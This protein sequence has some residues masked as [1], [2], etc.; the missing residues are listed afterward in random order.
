MNRDNK[1]AALDPALDHRREASRLRRI[2]V[3]SAAVGFRRGLH[4]E[5]FGLY[6]REMAD[7]TRVLVGADAFDFNPFSRRIR[8]EG[9]IAAEIASAM[10]LPVVRDEYQKCLRA[11][12]DARS[13]AL[14][15]GVAALQKRAELFGRGC[16]EL[17]EKC[18]RLRNALD[19]ST[20]DILDAM[21]SLRDV[22]DRLERE[23]PDE[24][25]PLPKYREM[26]F[27]Y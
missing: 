24:T 8:I 5:G 6:D 16:D 11:L 14:T 12:G 15:Q 20:E 22:A 27:I 17:D 19:N 3:G 21:T 1:P 4:L 13:A 18:A 23:A 7:P 9:G 26:L 2:E 25:W 10:I